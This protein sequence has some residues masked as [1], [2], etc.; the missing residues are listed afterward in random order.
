VARFPGTQLKEAALGAWSLVLLMDAALVAA[1]LLQAHTLAAL[2]LALALAWPLP[3]PAWHGLRHVLALPPACLLLWWQ[4]PPALQSLLPTLVERVQGL[5]GFRA[6]YLWELAQRSGLS[7]LLA[8][9]G[10]LTL[11]YLMFGHR[12]R[13]GAVAMAALALA[14]LSPRALDAS[15][16]RQLGAADQ[17]RTAQAVETVMAAQRAERGKV[18]S[19]ATAGQASFDLLLL[20]VCSLG[21]ADLR[22]AGLTE[23]PVLRDF[24]VVFPHFNS[25]ASYSGPAVLRLLR[26]S[27]GQP[28]QEA[29]YKEGTPDDCLLLRNLAAAGFAPALL[30]NHDGHF[31]DFAVTLQRLGGLDAAPADNHQAPVAMT[32]F[33]GSPVRADFPLLWSWWQANAR[34]ERHPALVYNTI[35]L[36]DG[37]HLDGAPAQG[38]L[39]SYR[40]RARHLLDGLGRLFAAI[41]ASGRPT[42]VVLVP[43][44]GAGL[45]ASEGAPAGLRELPTPDV[46]QVPVRVR[47]FGFGVAHGAGPVVVAGDTSYLALAT[48]V[49][50][51]MRSPPEQV[52]ADSLATLARALPRSAWLSE[53]DETR[54]LEHDGVGFLQLPGRDWAPAPNRAAPRRAG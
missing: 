7:W 26:A 39:A 10:L 4:A 41:E 34:G 40:N 49:A 52:Q 18:V 54:Y 22:A 48:L 53:G 9:A 35:T 33:D 8:G 36:H 6:G 16:A 1:G 44:H 11:A 46:T 20:S 3:R 43:E 15:T 25:A 24:D 30:L 51:L 47:L 23:H 31:D 38:M 50:G 2:A 12:L 14:P 21:D 19:F 27:C 29:L 5:A 45:G 28:P 13:F 17:A 37:N 42:V 32:G